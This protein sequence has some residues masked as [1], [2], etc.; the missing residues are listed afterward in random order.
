MASAVLGTCMQASTL[1]GSKHRPARAT[2]SALGGSR[3]RPARTAA[4]ALVGSKHRP[5]RAAAS[6]LGGP[7]PVARPGRLLVDAYRV[8]GAL[9]AVRVLSHGLAGRGLRQCAAI[10]SSVQPLC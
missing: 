9:R 2:A 3:H 6:A 4:S 1:G 5:A 8:R 7:I 10:L